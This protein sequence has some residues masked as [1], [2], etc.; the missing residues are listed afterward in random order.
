MAALCDARDSGDFTNPPRLWSEQPTRFS[1]EVSN[2][3]F[4]DLGALSPLSSEDLSPGQFQHQLY[5]LPDEDESTFTSSSAP[6]TPESVLSSVPSEEPYSSN[7]P[8]NVLP[9]LSYTWQHVKEE[10]LSPE[11]QVTEML[12]QNEAQ[13]D[14]NYAEL[15]GLGTGPMMLDDTP[16]PP[17]PPVDAQFDLVVM[18]RPRGC[19]GNYQEVDHLERIRVTKHKGKKLQVKLTSR[20]PG[21]EPDDIRLFLVNLTPPGRVETREGFT[22]ENREVTRCIT[23]STEDQVDD[24][25]ST[26]PVI[27]E[28]VLTLNRLCK[29]MAFCARCVIKSADYMAQTETFVAH[30]NGKNRVGAA[31][32]AAEAGGNS[33]AAK[34]RR[35][36]TAGESATTDGAAPSAVVEP[37]A[38][39]VVQGNL[40]VKGLVRAQGFQAYSDRRLKTDINDLMDA[41]QIVMQLQGK[42]YQWK[43]N[44]MA[45]IDT[46]GGK[47]V[48]GLIAQEVAEVLPAVV[49]IDAQGI[50]SVRYADLVPVLINAFKEHVQIYEEESQEMRASIAALGDRVLNIEV[51]KPSSQDNTESDSE[52][53]SD[54]DDFYRNASKPQPDP[55]TNGTATPTPTPTDGSTATPEPAKNLQPVLF[56]HALLSLVVKRRREFV[57]FYGQALVNRARDL[58]CGV[59]I[60]VDWSSESYDDV[61]L[62]IVKDDGSTVAAAYED[63]GVIA[64]LKVKAILLQCSDYEGLYRVGVRLPE[65]DVVTLEH[66]QAVISVFDFRHRHVR[67]H[68]DTRQ[69]PARDVGITEGGIGSFW[70]VGHLRLTKNPNFTNTVNELKK[71]MPVS[72]ENRIHP[73]SLDNSRVGRGLACSMEASMVEDDDDSCLAMDPTPTSSVVNDDDGDWVFVDEKAAAAAASSSKSKSKSSAVSKIVSEPVIQAGNKPNKPNKLL[74]PNPVRSSTKS[75]S[76]PSIPATRPT[77]RPSLVVPTPTQPITMGYSPTSPGRR[78]SGARTPPPPGYSMLMPTR[79]YTKKELRQMSKKEKKR[80]KHRE[81]MQHRD[82]NRAHHNMYAQYACYTPNAQAVP[83]V[84]TQAVNGNRTYYKVYSDPAATPAAMMQP[85]AHVQWNPVAAGYPVQTGYPH[86]R[87][88][89]FV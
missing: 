87:Q 30:N 65:T 31:A 21:L 57:R 69:L 68:R 39:T 81:K 77:A 55:P 89:G 54:E 13:V 37:E 63:S 7:S 67:G 86:Q 19:G 6:H 18:H 59:A 24:G 2:F 70:E 78:G 33:A 66:S 85:L 72:F 64:H 61:D 49:D 27:V 36:R 8:D 62:M 74:H 34:K 28:Y 41:V 56:P 53:D 38:P 11:H 48:I 44:N 15:N 3:N 29:Q 40:D 1:T 20:V 50:Y 5:N 71:K 35:K 60:M 4:E 58:R 10:P 14:H 76:A 46:Q 47:R 16:P 42:T 82:A 88:A 52:D 75:N 84:S 83:R 45:G 80:Q 25:T 32:A 9:Q 43:E 22:I 23:R 79:A 12:I 26:A 51:S 73:I 17:P